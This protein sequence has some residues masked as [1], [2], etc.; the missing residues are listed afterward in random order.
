MNLT[1]IYEIRTQRGFSQ[2][3]LARRSGVKQSIISDIERGKTANP[4]IDTLQKLAAALGC[5][6][7]ELASDTE[8]KTA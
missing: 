1:R 6:L 7:D 5:T 3:E 8:P 4:R 2:Q